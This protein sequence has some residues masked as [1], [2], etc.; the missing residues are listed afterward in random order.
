M[1]TLLINYQAKD[2]STQFCTDTDERDSL[3]TWLRKN[4]YL[5]NCFQY[6]HKNTIAYKTKYQLRKYGKNFP[7]KIWGLTRNVGRKSCAL[8]HF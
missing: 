6:L 7:A 4:L 2:N 1:G 8:L 3:F 5:N